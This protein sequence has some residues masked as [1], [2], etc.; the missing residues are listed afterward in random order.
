MCSF[1]TQPSK[2]SPIPETL[3]SKQRVIATSAKIIN[4]LG[5]QRYISLRRPGLSSI[6]ILDR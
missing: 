3:L 6:L 5:T 1:A 4:T 2:E